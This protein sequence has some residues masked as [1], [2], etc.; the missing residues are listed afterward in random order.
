MTSRADRLLCCAVAYR[1]AQGDGPSTLPETFENEG[2]GVA[3]MMSVLWHEASQAMNEPISPPDDA[4][5]HP[6]DIDTEEPGIVAHKKRQTDI[7]RRKLPLPSVVYTSCPASSRPSPPVAV[8]LPSPPRDFK[9]AVEEAEKSARK[10]VLAEQRQAKRDLKAEA[11]ALERREVAA[12]KKR[13]RAEETPEERDARLA[14]QRETRALKKATLAQA[15]PEEVA[16]KSSD[17]SNEKH[18]A[19]DSDELLQADEFRE[20]TVQEALEM[21]SA[22]AAHDAKLPRRLRARETKVRYFPSPV[23]FDRHLTALEETKLHDRIRAAILHA[24]PTTGLKIVHGP[25]GTG[26]TRRLAEMVKEF[27]NERIFACAPTNVGTANLYTRI[28]EVDP[29]ASLLIAPSKIPPGVPVV[30]QDPAAR[31]VCSTI[32]GRA[33]NLLNAHEFGVVMVDEAAQCMEAWIWC[34]LRAEVHTLVLVGDAQ[35]LPALVSEEGMTLRYDRSMLERLQSRD[36]PCEFLDT[37]RRMHPEIVKFP[38]ERFYQGRL[39]SDYAPATAACSTP[40]QVISVDGACEAIGHSFVNREEIRVCAA[41]V[42]ELEAQ[43]DKVV[44]ISPYQAQTREF[45][46]LGLSHVHTVDSF[47]G[48]EADAVVLSIV[49]RE[50]I[51][52]W[53]DE[54]RLNV[55]LTRARHCLRVVGAVDAWTGVLGALRDDANVRGLVTETARAAP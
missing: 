46:A 23:P 51:G 18:V 4:F 50:D 27:A 21:E 22:V 30:S 9:R 47:Q 25:P 16:S 33:G 11:S 1:N 48:Q 17:A 43:F 3:A 10:S 5:L 52:F 39:L 24:K 13:R 6:V 45:L 42:G 40:Y 37:Q 20:V 36:Y 28:L 26:K 15:T 19:D 12:D 55:A 8:R 49:R 44:V 14:A 38:N 2:V 32:S 35:Q 34:L 29:E 41:L 31:I 54:R 7:L 53:Q